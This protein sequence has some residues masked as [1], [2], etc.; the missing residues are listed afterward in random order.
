VRSTLR[1]TIGAPSNP[2]PGRNPIYQAWPRPERGFIHT[3]ISSEGKLAYLFDDWAM[4]LNAAFGANP[5]SGFRY[6]D[7]DGIVRPGDSWRADY[8]TGDGVMTY[9]Y[10]LAGV[11]ASAQRRRPVILN[12]AFRSVGELGY[13]FRDQ[14]FKTLDFWSDKSADSGLLELFCAS[15]QTGDY[16]AGQVNPNAATAKVWQALLQ[17]AA[18]QASD[19]TQTVQSSEATAMVQAVV[20]DLAAQGPLSN[21]S[22]LVTRL[23]S[24]LYA[25]FAGVANTATQKPANNKTYGETPVRALSENLSGRTWNLLIDVA[26][27]TGRIGMQASGLE[28]FMVEGERHYWM[29][30]AID[31]YTGEVVDRQLE[32]Y[33]E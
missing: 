26:A 10:N 7:K 28:D 24:A 8:T 33:Y 15:E 31:R 12:R 18:K 5:V 25:A 17:G 1:L 32:P 6:E 14:P 3:P 21:P 2:G 4:N 20:A 22:E 11:T 9:H 16:R 13:V 19:L 27:Q 29:H 30:I 23:S